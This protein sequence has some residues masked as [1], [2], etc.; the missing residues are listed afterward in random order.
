MKTAIILGA[1]GLTGSLV[2]EQLI[3]NTNYSKIK[4][5]SRSASGITNP[6]V[7]EHIVDLLNLESVASSFTADEVYCCIGTTKK[8]TPD[9]ALYR[10]ID[11]G[12]PAMA[13]KLC[14]ANGIKTLSVVSAIGANPNSSI[15][16]NRTK[17]EM[18]QAIL[19][20]GIERTYILRPSII[21]GNRQEKRTGEKV[22]LSVFRF[23]KPIFIGKLKKYAVVD[24]SK[25]AAKMI[26]L[27]NSTSPSCIIE[28]NDI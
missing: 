28:S 24:P 3:A 13:A 21:G 26:M 11:Y 14:H 5:F 16:Y 19:S 15:F 18:E 4:L 12:I 6:K 27:S 17:G 10:S 25:I 2:L 1:T 9:Q 23:L 22:G 20:A 8:K 7:E